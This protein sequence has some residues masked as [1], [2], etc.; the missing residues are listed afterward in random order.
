MRRAYINITGRIPTTEEAGSFINDGSQDKR[1]KL[2]DTL[3]DSEGYKSRM[4]NFWADLLRVQTNLD[5]H[6]LGWHVWI[7]KAVD[8]NM[9]Y[10]DFVHAMLSSNG[11]VSDN[12]AVGYYL[13]DREMLLDNVSNTTEVFLGTQIGCA[14]CHDHPFDDWTQKQYFELAAFIGNTT[15]KSD[16]AKHLLGNLV[17]YSFEKDGKL[18]GKQGEQ[19]RK[20]AMRKKGAAGKYYKDYSS[21]FKDFG[22]VAVSEDPKKTLRL[23]KDYQ[24]NDGKPGDILIPKTLFG[25][26]ISDNVPLEQRREAFAHWV[27]SSENPLFTKVIVNRLWAEVFGRGIVD[28]LDD[29]SDTKRISHP[30][31]LDYLAQFFIDNKWSTK[32]LI[33]KIV[34]SK[35]YQMS[36]Y[37]NEKTLKEDPENQLFSRQNRRRLEAEAIRDAMLLASGQ[38]TFENSKANQNRSLFQKIDRNKIPEIFAVFDYP[39]PGLVSGN[40]NTS[41]VPTQALFMM[42]SDFVMRQAVL[43]V[44]NIFGRKSVDVERKIKLVFLSCLGREPNYDEKKLVYSYLDQSLNGETRAKAM[45]GLVHSLFACLDF[46]YLN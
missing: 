45:E 14:Q 38:I 28:P 7:H 40:R 12:A 42:N 34:L 8:Q 36:S 21:L 11:M 9:P 33:R 19:S 27:T 41:T 16:A 2:V 46:R 17:K 25:E 15:Y 3:I 23:P 6:G 35:T 37:A 5:K 29:W 32:R 18:K 44:Q 31:L 24:Y 43:T 10:D 22:K 4:F 1:R 20:L 13:R 39:N 30:E 26:A